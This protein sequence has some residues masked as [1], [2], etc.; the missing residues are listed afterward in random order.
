MTLTW[1]ETSG[2]WHQGAV[3]GLVYV[4]VKRQAPHEDLIKGPHTVPGAVRG[5]NLKV[6]T[7]C[8]APYEDHYLFKVPNA[9][10]VSDTV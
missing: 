6:P 4:L 9:H 1:L 5:L 3:E 10:T 2:H 8:Q 7:R